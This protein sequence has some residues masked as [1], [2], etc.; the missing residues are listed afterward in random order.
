MKKQSPAKAQ[1]RKGRREESFQH[2]SAFFAP[3]RLCA[4]LSD[5]NIPSTFI[6]PTK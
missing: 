1:R 3:L 2:L 6:K 4:K 5:S